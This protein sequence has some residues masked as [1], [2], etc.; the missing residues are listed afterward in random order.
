MDYNKDANVGLL[1]NK[2]KAFK[3]PQCSNQDIELQEID[4]QQYVS[5][6]DAQQCTIS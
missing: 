3:E 5:F 6:E 4:Q 2:T 1:S